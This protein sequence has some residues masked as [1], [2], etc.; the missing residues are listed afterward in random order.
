[1]RARAGSAWWRWGRSGSDL[2]CGHWGSRETCS[3]RLTIDGG[4]HSES[5][6]EPA[7]ADGRGSATG[8]LHPRSAVDEEPSPCRFHTHP[9]CRPAAHVLHDLTA[10]HPKAWRRE[11]G[12]ACQEMW[13]FPVLPA[14]ANPLGDMRGCV[15]PLKVERHRFAPPLSTANDTVTAAGQPRVKEQRSRPVTRPLW[16]PSMRVRG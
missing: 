9:S 13:D 8:V 12:T 3:A 6:K 11:M 16:R 2:A 15:S 5:R 4:R 14:R 7:A 1:M 10:I